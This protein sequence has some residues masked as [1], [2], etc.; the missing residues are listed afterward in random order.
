MLEAS[1][2]CL[3]HLADGAGPCSLSFYCTFR[4][5]G[6]GPINSA[7]LPSSQYLRHI[8]VLCDFSELTLEACPFRLVEVMS[9]SAWWLS[10]L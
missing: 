8:E 7:A 5:L 4:F 3:S 6:T 9:W 2:S 10:V 1:T